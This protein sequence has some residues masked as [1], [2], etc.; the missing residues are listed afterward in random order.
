MSYWHRCKLIN[1][2]C[3]QVNRRNFDRSIAPVRAPRPRARSR[4]NEVVV[5]VVV[6]VVG[7]D[8]DT[9][10]AAALFARCS[11]VKGSIKLI[12]RMEARAAS[13]ICKR[14]LAD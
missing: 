10:Q 8:E 2:P 4:R 6:V 7:D 12:R 11:G 1:P 5:V 3:L 14:E 13:Y 9:K